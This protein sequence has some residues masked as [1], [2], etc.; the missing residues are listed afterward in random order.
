MREWRRGNY[1]EDEQENQEREHIQIEVNRVYDDDDLEDKL[2]RV[3]IR[4]LKLNANRR[5]IIN[6]T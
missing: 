1:N 2:E 3:Y 6:E 4:L 5:N